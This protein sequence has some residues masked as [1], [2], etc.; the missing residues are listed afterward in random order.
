MVNTILTNQSP[1]CT[2]HVEVKPIR[3]VPVQYWLHS[4][5]DT[6]NGQV[7]GEQMLNQQ[8][9]SKYHDELAQTNQ[10]YF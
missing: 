6:G 1:H 10:Y 5:S 4:L 2:S 8:V 9:I 7:M 3:T